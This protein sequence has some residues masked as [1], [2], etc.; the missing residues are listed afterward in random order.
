[1]SGLFRSCLGLGLGS[2]VGTPWSDVGVKKDAT[3]VRA[4]FL[5][6]AR[7]ESGLEIKHAP[8]PRNRRCA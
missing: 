7:D 8:H 1:M 2:H 4:V 3:D 6:F 5:K